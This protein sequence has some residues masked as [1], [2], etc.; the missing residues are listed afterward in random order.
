MASASSTL[1][2]AWVPDD[3]PER[4]WEIA[5][6]LAVAW[7]RQECAEQGAVG[8]LVLNAFG[9]EQQI[10]SLRR[11]AAEHAVTTPRASRDRVARGK[12][13]V[14]AYVPDERTLD[15]AASLARGSSLA[16][17]ESVHG[18]PLE[19]W[20]CQLGAIDL[21]RPDEQPEQLDSELA[22][23]IDR[24]DFHKNNGF[25]DQF[26]K[27]QAQRI[28]QDLRD[29]GLLERDIVLGALAAKGASDRAVRNIGKLIDA[30]DRR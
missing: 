25:G 9:V 11:L 10:P 22:D 24:L 23:A 7:V 2:A 3:D 6:D 18:F 30:L 14:L 13:P 15:F 28:L 17:V 16:I 8:V 4:D 19:G 27:Q 12:G 1:R 5:A 26:G 29:A 20:A 21:T